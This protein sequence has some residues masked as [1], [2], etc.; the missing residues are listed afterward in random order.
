MLSLHATRTAALFQGFIFLLCIRNGTCQ[1]CNSNGVCDNHK[2]CSKWKDEGECYRS[3]SYMSRFCPASCMDTKQSPRRNE[4]K[5]VHQNCLIWSQDSECESNTSVARFCPLSCG[6]CKVAKNTAENGTLLTGADSTRRNAMEDTNQCKDN[7]ENCIAW[8][9]MGECRKNEGYM[10]AQCKKACGKCESVATDKVEDIDLTIK[11]SAK[12]GVTQIAEGAKRQKILKKITSTINYI[13]SNNEYLTLP[14]ATR[15]NCKNNHELCSFWAVVGECQN[16]VGFMKIKCAPACESCHLI[17]M[18]NRCP[19]I[20]DAIPGL[21]SGDLN[22]VFERIAEMAP[23]NRTLTDQERRQLEDSEMTEYS[24]TVHSRPSDEPV[25]EA[26][27]ALDKSLPPWVITFDNLLTDEECDS[28]IQHGFDAGYKRSEDV[29]QQKFDGTLTSKKSIGRTSENAWC[30]TRNGCRT[31]TV[32]KRVLDR[33]TSIVGIPP[34]NSEDLQ[35][36]KYEVGQFY[37]THHDYI[38]H[39]KE[40]QC[41]PRILTFFL[42][43]SDVEAGGGTDFPDL[44]ITVSPK[45]G[46][47]V[48]WPSVY[49]SHPMEVDNRMRHQALPVIA[50]TKFGANAW[51]H[52]FDYM[53]PQANGCN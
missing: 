39:Q 53:E 22:E 51:I 5:D 48:L 16:N 36:L 40:R 47:A 23:G 38:P 4:C 43:L 24:V 19:K 33:M 30:T 11:L 14:V 13:E 6:R 15:E 8:A 45:K 28:L 37:N 25:A 32:P 3:P 1:K 21:K 46:R 29:G 2:R 17:D 31:Q 35:I 42:Y 18:A 26:E 20:P 49:S 34:E 12:F 10:S 50:G 44:G 41:G 9:D 52:M 27:L 7:N